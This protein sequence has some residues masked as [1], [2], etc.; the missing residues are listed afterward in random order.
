MGV[1]PELVIDV[2]R[3]DIVMRGRR[4]VVFRYYAVSICWVESS[5]L[6]IVSQVVPS[7]S[8]VIRAFSQL[9]RARQ[10]VSEI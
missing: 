9:A 4:T 3:M 2:L 7:C 5:S 8:P 6:A 10:R 1:S